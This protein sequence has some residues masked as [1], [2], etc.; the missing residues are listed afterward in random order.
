MA[1]MIK[2]INPGINQTQF[3]EILRSTSKDLGDSGYDEYY[4]YGL[5]DFG[6]AFE[7]IMAH[8]S[9]Y[10]LSL[11]TTVYDYNGSAKAPSVALSYG[12]IRLINGRDYRVSYPAGRTAVGTYRITVSGING[13]YGSKTATFQIRPPLIKSIKA[14]QRYKGKL[15]V[16]WY[17]MSKSQRKN[18][19]NVI[20]GYQVRVSTY[21]NFAY[22]KYANVKGITKTAATVKGLKRKTY[23]YVQY[24]SYKTVGSTTYYS[25]WSG[26]KRAKTK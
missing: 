18:Y 10:Q 14:P 16:R 25:K 8:L 23:Y 7:Y 12:S 19:K 20:T 2:S 9:T 6:K 15:K 22:A 13:Y 11:S 1:A 17:K 4:G 21:K 24:R 26:T 5:I 3:M